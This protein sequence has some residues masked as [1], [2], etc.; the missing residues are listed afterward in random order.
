MTSG[1]CCGDGPGG[2]RIDGNCSRSPARTSSISSGVIWGD[3]GD[4]DSSPKIDDDGEPDSDMISGEAGDPV[5]DFGMLL[6]AAA[7]SGD[8]SV[9]ASTNAWRSSVLV[10]MDILG[11]GTPATI[12][13]TPKSSVDVPT[14][15]DRSTTSDVS[16]RDVVGMAALMIPAV[17]D[18]GAG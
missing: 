6:F 9:H 15:R 14:S 4:N 1:W 11:I 12:T 8:V 18:D 10:P 7:A 13:A 5:T 17:A 2:P 3:D 16:L